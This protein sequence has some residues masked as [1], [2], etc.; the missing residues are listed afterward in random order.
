VLKISTA[1]APAAWALAAFTPK[2]HVPRWSSAMFPGTKSAKSPASH[3]LVLAAFSPVVPTACTG[4]VTVP[5][6][7]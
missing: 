1:E 5:E 3:P 2:A 6:P 7:E 4:A